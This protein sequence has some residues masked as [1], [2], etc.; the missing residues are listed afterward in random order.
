MNQQPSDNEFLLRMRQATV[1]KGRQQRVLDSISLD[2]RQ[3]EQTIILGPNGS[4]KSSLIKLIMRQ[5]YP[6]IHPDGAPALLLYGR[7]RWDVSELRKHLGIVSADMSQFFLSG[8]SH[9]DI[10]GLDVVISGFFASVGLFPHH[11]VTPAMRQRGLEALAL[12]EIHHLAQKPIAAMSTGEARRLLI[13]RALAPDPR[14]LLL[15]EPTTGLDLLARQR[16]LETLRTLA[17]ADKTLLLVTHHIEEI[18]P[19]VERV[20]LLKAGRVFLDGPKH[21]ILTTQHLSA[22]YDAPIHVHSDA[23]GYYTASVGG[24]AS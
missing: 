23:A 15:D 16:F 22:L 6:L 3:G 13:A 20:I 21:A 24:S 10:S 2:I 7:A 9:Q 12:M 8:V 19:E 4:G 14:A 11:E 5:D 18:L 17:R 1:V